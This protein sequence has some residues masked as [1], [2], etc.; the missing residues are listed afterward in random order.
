MAGD[1]LKSHA[2]EALDAFWDGEMV[3]P[4][5]DTCSVVLHLKGLLMSLAK[6]HQ[7]QQPFTSPFLASRRLMQEMNS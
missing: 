2:L 5:G 6:I 1:R 3:R 4:A 7:P